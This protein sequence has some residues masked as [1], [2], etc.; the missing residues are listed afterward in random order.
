MR[1]ALISV[2]GCPLAQPGSRDTGGM[3][4]YLREVGRELG[5][6]G[7]EV[8]IFT[9]SHPRE[10]PPR[11]E[12]G[13][14]VRLIHLAAGEPLTAKEDLYLHLPEFALN[15]QRFQE[16]EGHHYHLIHSHYW[17]SG[18]VGNILKNRWKVPHV[19]TFHTLGEMKTRSGAGGQESQL[20][21]ETERQEIAQADL[22][23]ANSRREKEDLLR[24]YGVSPSR[25][26]VVPCGVNADLFHPLN[27][28]QARRTLGLAEPKILLYVGRLDPLKGIDLL[29][30]AAALLEDNQDLRVIIVGG[31]EQD[32]K[33][34]LR[35]RLL[36]Q[37]L[38]LGD[39]VTFLG[40]VTQERLNLLY[41]AASACVMPSY[42]ESF[43]MVAL[44]ALACGTPVVATRVGA[45]PV[46][47]R[48]GETGFLLPWHCPEPFAE[49]LDLL[50]TSKT[51]QHGFRQ[52][53][54]AS[55]MGFRWSLVAGR[56]L[57]IYR[58]LIGELQSYTSESPGPLPQCPGAH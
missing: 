35:L 34:R 28:E 1:I 45:L 10:E 17:L 57:T 12:L 41:N 19:I 9:R 4:V 54:R 14:G 26:E 40:S 23:V 37:G 31:D 32:E 58:R 3:N 47:I 56:M 5:R 52:A 39:R 36:A 24:F 42:Y 21:L 44:E 38:G 13:P 25:V 49:K 29:L 2:H 22:I 11:R 51:L 50:L 53:A 16:R 48:D 7:V 6:M 18:W 15:L 30:Q 55:V 33:E 27:K 43:G 20:R 46:A 8:D